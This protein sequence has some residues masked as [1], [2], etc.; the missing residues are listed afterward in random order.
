MR[1]ITIEKLFGDHDIKI[2]LD[3][4]LSIMIG[5]NG[6]GKSTVLKIIQLVNQL[7]FISLARYN[8][9]RITLVTESNSV[10]IK[11]EDLFPVLESLLTDIEEGIVNYIGNAT[12]AYNYFA[13]GLRTA[14]KNKP[15]I[16]YEYLASCFFELP[17]S[18]KVRHNMDSSC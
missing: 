2:D 16:Y 7:D 13:S 15:S 5:E 4:K 9:K 10:A 18:N 12:I 8:F 14:L 1:I 11:R 6:I 3:Q 17:F